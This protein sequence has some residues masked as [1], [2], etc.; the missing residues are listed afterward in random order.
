MYVFD[1][2]MLGFHKHMT[3]TPHSCGMGNLLESS[4][5]YMCAISFRCFHILHM[6]LHFAKDRRPHSFRNICFAHKI[7]YFSPMFDWKCLI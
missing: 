4:Y 1:W 6:F 5:N 7:L 3:G 2:N